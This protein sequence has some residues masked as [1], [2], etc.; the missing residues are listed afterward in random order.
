ME[1]VRAGFGVDGSVEHFTH[2]DLQARRETMRR[3]LAENAKR[4]RGKA[5]KP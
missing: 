3:R 1:G 2:R 5:R 4:V